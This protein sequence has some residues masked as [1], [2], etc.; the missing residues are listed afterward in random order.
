MNIGLVLD[1]RPRELS[2]KK[3]ILHIH[4]DLRLEY[5]FGRIGLI[6]NYFLKCGGLRLEILFGILA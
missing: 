5:I 4:I 6:W 2:Q 1:D 3:L